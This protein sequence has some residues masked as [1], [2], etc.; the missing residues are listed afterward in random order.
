MLELLMYKNLYYYYI[1]IYMVDF[2]GNRKLE[3]IDGSNSTRLTRLFLLILSRSIVIIS[4]SDDRKI[5]FKKN[6]KNM[7]MYLKVDTSNVF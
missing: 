1:Y 6:N 3:N 7:Y 5:E 4:H 2:E